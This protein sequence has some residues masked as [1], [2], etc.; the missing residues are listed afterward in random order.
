MEYGWQGWEQMH[1]LDFTEMK[2]IMHYAMWFFHNL[3]F[4]RRTVEHKHSI[5]DMLMQEAGTEYLKSWQIK[6][7]KPDN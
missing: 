2:I 5:D 6:K 4:I 1:G 3:K 7:T